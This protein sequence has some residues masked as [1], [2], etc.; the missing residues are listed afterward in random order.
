MLRFETDAKNLHLTPHVDVEDRQTKLFS[1][2]PLLTYLIIL[3]WNMNIQTLHIFHEN[4]VKTFHVGVIFTIILI[5][6]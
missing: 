5:F 1:F 2:L 4:V 6:L 3:N